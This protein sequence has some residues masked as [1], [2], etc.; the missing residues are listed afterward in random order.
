MQTDTSDVGLGA[1]L[2]QEVESQ[3]QVIEFASRV[4]TPADRTYSVTERECLAVVWAI[5]KI[6]PYIEGN[7][8]KVVTDHSSLRWLCQM[9]NPMS[10]L[11]RWAL[12]LQGH[13]FMVDHRKST[14]NHV[15]HALSQLYEDE[16]GPEVAAV[17]WSTDTEDSWYRS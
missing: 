7:E 9:K 13:K 16:D 1:V 8:F 5:Q 17:S 2:L 15:A 12:E 11:A 3:G 14:L 6:R 10:R 4:L